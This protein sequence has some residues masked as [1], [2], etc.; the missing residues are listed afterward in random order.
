MS[1]TIYATGGCQCGAV[2]YAFLSAP[3]KSHVCHCRMCQ[4][5]VGN[6]FATLVGAPKTNIRWTSREPSYFASSSL[7]KRGFCEKCG[8]PLTFAYDKPDAHLFVTTGSLD[9]PAMVPIERQFG[10]ESRIRWV[11]FCEDVPSEITGASEKA[12]TFLTGMKNNQR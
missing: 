9:D 1:D 8:T 3:E 10:V 5:A 11:D 6:V 4:K 7:A 2:R 12:S